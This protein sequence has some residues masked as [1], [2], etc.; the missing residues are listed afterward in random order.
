MSE[1]LNV[2][3]SN[4][5]FGYLGR[6]RPTT[7]IVEHLLQWPEQR[8]YRWF[9]RKYPQSFRV[10]LA[11]MLG[12]VSDE[13]EELEDD[14]RLEMVELYLEKAL[15]AAG[16]GGIEDIE[17]AVNMLLTKIANLARSL[18]EVDELEIDYGIQREGQSYHVLRQIPDNE[19]EIWS[20]SPLF[21]KDTWKSAAVYDHILQAYLARFTAETEVDE[22]DD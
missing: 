17:E 14:E 4:A 9:A 3:V 5:L 15:S 6:K 11:E 1:V 10:L 12:Y 8:F 19:W 18:Q 20:A 2:M 21:D 22:A 13:S 7:V 16:I